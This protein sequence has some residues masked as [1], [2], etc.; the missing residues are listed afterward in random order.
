MSLRDKN[1]LKDQHL[2]K[3]LQNAPD[4]D[5]APSDATRKTVLGY[6][7]KA[8][9]LRRDSWLTRAINAFNHWQLP[10]WQLA[11]MGSLA[12][13]FLVVVMIWHENPEDP[14]QVATAP[15]A[16]QSEIVQSE[17]APR[18][19]QSPQ[20]AAPATETMSA[21]VAASAEIAAPKVPDKMEEKAVA[22]TKP[23]KPETA[24]QGAA[25]E[26][27]SDKTIVAS[28]PEAASTQE[29]AKDTSSVRLK[30]GAASNEAASMPAPVAAAPVPVA[31]SAPVAASA[32]A[33]GDAMTNQAT[34]SN[35]AVKKMA[36]AEAQ[37][38]A[39][40]DNSRPENSRPENSVAAAAKP[41]LA[42]NITLAQAISKEGGQAMAN[43]DIQAGNL[44]ILYLRK[45][46]P[47]AAPLLDEVTGYRTELIAD[48][49][50]N[51][52][53]EVAAYNQA[54]RDWHLNQNQ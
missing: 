23:A 22:K 50:A 7:D 27:P 18:A 19:E 41:A 31:E 15:E 16:A 12:V 34:P 36:D 5:I 13:S 9:K 40:S 6:A 14:I 32:E 24:P 39:K 42:R 44:R 49:A 2:L 53:A 30:E 54:M 51:L 4:S 21:P 11:G 25:I 37:L 52:A 3:A 20:V 45:S 29:V 43:K 1:L 26:A 10:R 38:E 48:D 28:A 17:A 46:A 35:K 8:V 47:T 33:S